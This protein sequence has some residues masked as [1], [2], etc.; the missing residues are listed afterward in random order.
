[1]NDF[2]WQQAYEIGGGNP[3]Y[4]AAKAGPWDPRQ[5]TTFAWYRFYQYYGYDSG[6]R[7]SGWINAE[8]VVAAHS[9]KFVESSDPAPGSIVSFPRHSGESGW[10]CCI[11]RKGRRNTVWYSDGNWGVGNIRLN[12]KTSVQEM[13][14]LYC[15]NG[16][17]IEYAVPKK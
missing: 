15:Q 7:G 11:C 6:A 9:D 10:T 3:F 4:Y 5:C 16:E 8:Q 14:A 2:I 13:N 1:M 17:R 12:K